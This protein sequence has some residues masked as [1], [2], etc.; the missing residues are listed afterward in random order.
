MGVHRR[1]SAAEDFWKC[2]VVDA[3]LWNYKVFG[4]RGS[5]TEANRQDT[6]EQN[7]TV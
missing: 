2:P 5:F 7:P 3:F 6:V 1:T 4:V